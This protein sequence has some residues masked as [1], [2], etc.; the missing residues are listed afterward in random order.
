M[1][2]FFDKLGK[3]VQKTFSNSSSNHHHNRGGGKTLGGTKAGTY[4]PNIIIAQ[5]GPLGIQIE[6]T[7]DN[8]YAIIAN[9]VK[10]G[11]GDNVGLQRGDVICH[12]SNSSSGGGI[13]NS[14]ISNSD[15]SGKEM[16][17]KEFLQMVKSN[18]RPLKF[19]VRR[20]IIQSQQSKNNT[21]ATN[22]NTNANTSNSNNKINNNNVRADADARRQ[23]VI[24]AAEQ[25]SSTHKSKTKPIPK[26][27]GGKV[28]PELTP[29]EIQK[30][31]LQKEENIKRNEMYMTNEPMSLE[32]KR[33]IEAAKKGEMEDIH[34]LGYNPYEVRKVTAGQASSA[35]IAMNH[36]AI[37]ATGGGGGGGGGSSNSNPN[38]NQSIPSI[39]PPPNAMVAATSSPSTSSRTRPINT[40]FDEALNDLVTSNPK[41]SISKS[42]RIINKLITNASSSTTPLDDPKR[43]IRIS[44]EPN[45]L[46]QSCVIDMNGA[47]ELLIS[48]GFVMM[49]D[50]DEKTVLFYGDQE[51]VSWLR[52]ALEKMEQYEN[53]YKI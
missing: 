24:A 34:S 40:I 9:V 26:K 14:N 25:R 36:G 17:Y 45:A 39:Q 23:A 47:I 42:L 16:Q 52:D 13:S 44:P 2:G 43:K 3:D 8:N 7:I 46:I 27:K 48:V 21:T 33:A 28:I 19:D 4:I 51:E 53:E 31:T 37:S 29:D 22:N 6:N 12:P 20:M 1:K 10:G 38:N 35:A 32:A 18:Q 11:L 5:P 49:E 50:D 15:G 41:Q 30:L